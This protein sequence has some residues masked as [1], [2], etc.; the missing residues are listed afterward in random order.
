MQPT[1]IELRAEPRIPVSFK[2]TLR[3]GDKSSPCV[4]QNMCSRGFL[5]KAE[6]SLP[7]GHLVH[8]RCELYPERCIECTVQVRHV[9][10]QCLG[11]KVIQ[12][13]EA[14]RLLCQQYLEEQRSRIAA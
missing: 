12:I 8:L 11:A 4:V 5:I 14:E 7:V 6:D 2:G 1:G 10:R 3:A 9:N 13:S